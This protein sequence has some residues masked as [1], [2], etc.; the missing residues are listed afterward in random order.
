MR[1]IALIT[2]ASGELGSAIALAVAQQG[3]DLV[4]HY[5][6]N[7]KRIE[8]IENKSKRYGVQTWSVRANFQ[9]I[10]EIEQMFDDLNGWNVYPNILINNAAIS[11][12][13][14]I[15][16]VSVENW[17]A[18]VNTNLG[19]AFFC[20]KK[21]IPEM[22]RLRYGRIVN[23]SSVWGET[24]AA[25]EVLYSISKGALNTFTKALAKE[26]APSGITVNAIAP[27]F[28]QSSMTKDFTD[29]EL[30]MIKNQIP[31]NRFADSKEIAQT[32]IHLL[33]DHS[34]YITG[35]ILT[36]DGGWTI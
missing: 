36:I 28:F 22:I 6:T 8:E 9:N 15:Q 10:S 21:V 23:I 18:V 34:S 12:Y 26:L 30:K 5:H 19:G 20:A 33:D 29:E 3:I 2:G 17:E 1:K 27:G 25:N 35:Q 16:E 31:M 11:H 7:G 13:G 4:L 32:V 24:G 14:L